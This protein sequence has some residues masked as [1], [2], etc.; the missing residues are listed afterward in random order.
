MDSIDDTFT[1][2]L[3]MVADDIARAAGQVTVALLGPNLCGHG[4]G[5]E[6]QLCVEIWNPWDEDVD[7]YAFEV[8]REPADDPDQFLLAA[9]RAFVMWLDDHHVTCDQTLEDVRLPVHD[10]LVLTATFDGRGLE[11]PGG[12][13]GSAGLTYLLSS[14]SLRARVA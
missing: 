1:D 9:A 5:A 14:D 8:R 11:D 13:S 3:N 12:Y 4:S 6:G 10:Q 7:S 2:Q